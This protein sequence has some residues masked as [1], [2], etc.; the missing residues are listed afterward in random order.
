M[1][2]KKTT[3]EFISE[4]EM[5]HG[6][7]YDYSK[8]DYINAKT[9]VII[10]CPTHGEF[11]QIP[12]N[13]IKGDDC[14]KCKGLYMDTEYFKE[15]AKKKYGGF[16]NYSK[17]NYI[18]NKTKISII[19]PIHGEFNQKPKDHLIGK[20]CPK[21]SGTYMDT[22]YFIDK[23]ILIHKLNYD[24]SKVNYVNS[25]TKINIICP[26]HGKF[27]Q[28]PS[29]HLNGKGCPKCKESK[30]EREIRL[31][32]EDNNIKYLPQHTFPDC[33]NKRE[34][35]FDFYLPKY[36]LCI[37]YN[38]IQH[39]EPIKH[40]GGIKKFNKTIN[41]DTIKCNYCNNNDINLIIINDIKNVIKILQLIL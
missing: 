3:S 21:C 5:I 40:F 7:K 39:Y 14:P 29:S 30:G 25:K 23:A 33:K 28:I 11:K 19:C 36:N 12:R 24:Y 17:V 2:K 38:G 8:V 31:W 1:S 18:N 9:K 4:A 22:E 34:L 20:Q 26:I 6:N 27:E 32:L 15:K 35:P 10:V 16:Y 37:E 13:H 41:N